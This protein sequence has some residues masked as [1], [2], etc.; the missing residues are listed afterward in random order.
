[1]GDVTILVSPAEPP[2]LRKLGETSF[3]VEEYGADF[4]I[5]GEAGI[6][7]LQRK[8]FPG[9][10]LSSVSDGRLHT[11]V[12]KLTATTLPLIVLEGRPRWTLDG[13][14]LDSHGPDLKRTTLRAM[15]WSLMSAGIGV[16][17]SDGLNDTAAYIGALAKWWAKD[18][19]DGFATRPGPGRANEFGKPLSKRDW[20]IHVLQGFDGVGPQLAGRIYDEFECLPLRWDVTA[21]E[22]GS[23]HGLGPKRLATLTGNVAAKEES[24][25]DD[26]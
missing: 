9:D 5:V 25:D 17:W 11:V 21:A 26:D 2:A 8:Q 24:D 1:M 23:V 22:L 20:A 10:F 16:Q 7:G 13:A 3:A 12:M 4:L 19:H 15:E 14:L 6:I 18:D